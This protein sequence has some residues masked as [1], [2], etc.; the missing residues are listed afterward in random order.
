MTEFLQSGWQQLSHLTTV[1]YL[2]IGSSVLLLLLSS[3]IF[4][5]IFKLPTASSQYAKKLQTFRAVLFLIIA[6]LILNRFILSDETHDNLATN[7]LGV[8]IIVFAAF[9]IIQI[10][11]FFIR[12]QYGQTRDFSGET[13]V[14]DSYNSRLL[15]LIA[16]VLIVIFALIS[17]IRVLGFEGLL[18]AGGIIG[19][20]GVMLALTQG[21][22]APDVISGL[23]ILN[24][25][26]LNSGEIVELDDG[27]IVAQVFRIKLF[28]TELLNVVHNNRI[29]IR[30]SKLRDKT[31][32][33]LSKAS[34][35]RGY[36]EKQVFKIGYDA[37]VA[38]VK[39]MFERVYENAVKD[40]EIAIEENHA[41]EVRVQDAGDYAVEW[42]VYYYTKQLRYVI[43]TR[44][45][46][47]ELALKESI[48]SG[49]SL[50]TPDLY[51]RV[52]EAE[53]VASPVR[54][55][56]NLNPNP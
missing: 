24:S 34:S 46:F 21:S 44:Q 2:L 6:A 22:W 19:F 15:G 45:L 5:H 13:V 39:A 16:T 50:A 3:L 43:K 26:L 9:W 48:R 12:R 10:L 36:R 17:I 32:H 11:Q 7:L 41:L 51:Q 29:L 49:I 42:A 54:I 14:T 55:E 52:S 20:I 33:N 30:N 27:D 31:I 18:E 56:D 25:D 28:H 1:E 38:E 53:P 8:I 4:K 40:S 23:V 47:K 37:D 35:A